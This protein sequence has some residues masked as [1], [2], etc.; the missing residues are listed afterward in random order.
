[1]P[2]DRKEIKLRRSDQQASPKA[3]KITG[4]VLVLSHASRS[5]PTVISSG[6][7]IF[8][9]PGCCN[10]R[11]VLSEG[12]KNYFKDW[13]DMNSQKLKEMAIFAIFSK[14]H[15][16]WITPLSKT[17]LYQYSKVFV[18]ISLDVNLS[19]NQ[20]LIIILLYVRQTWMMLLILVIFQRGVIF[21]YLERIVT[22]MHG[23]AVYVKDRLP[24]TWN[25]PLEN[26]V[27]SY[28]CFHLA[29]LNSLSHSFPSIDHLPHFCALCLVL[30]YRIQRRFSWSNNLLY[31]SLETLT[32]IIKAD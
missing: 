23:S 17:S 29:L 9:V 32:S 25:L 4:K 15:K 21:L 16:L 2:P 1:M 18:Q 26:S 5:V 31:F 10:Y 30:F 22:H 6:M 11:W 20:T 28:L 14:V 13:C 19:L 12:H 3:S 27:D 24:I 8:E 7:D